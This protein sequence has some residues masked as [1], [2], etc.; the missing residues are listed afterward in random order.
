MGCDGRILMSEVFRKRQE[1]CLIHIY[2]IEV[3]I[4]GLHLTYLTLSPTNPLEI[5]SVL[6]L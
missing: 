5:P 3:S 1:R 6:L 4:I 2:W